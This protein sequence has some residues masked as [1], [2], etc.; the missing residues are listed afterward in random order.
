[1]LKTVIAISFLTIPVVTMAKDVY[2]GIKIRTQKKKNPFVLWCGN[3]S[4]NVKLSPHLLVGGL[5]GTG[6]TKFVES[7]F[8]NRDDVDIYLLNAFREDFKG[9]NCVR[10]NNVND[11][12][13]LLSD[14]TKGKLEGI[15]RNSQSQ[16]CYII[17]DELLELSIRNKQIIKELT[18]AIATSR[19]FN[20]FFICISQS[21]TKEEIQAKALFNQRVC[22]K[23]IESSS[24]NTILGYSPEDR[25][26]QQLNQREFYY[27]N[28]SRTG[29]SR[30]PVV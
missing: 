30:V 29:R 21:A 6:K 16:P 15:Y 23:C 14:I 11:I 17:I 25:N 19:H 18:K 3:I 5:S 12:L 1:M 2:K 26:N 22:F 7:L 28:D 4:F 20:I 24:Y 13:I 27:R 10:I 9:I 8:I